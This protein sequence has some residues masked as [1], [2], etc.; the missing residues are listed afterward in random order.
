MRRFRYHTDPTGR[1]RKANAEYMKKARSSPKRKK[2]LYANHLMRKYG[3][4]IERYEEML[5][6]QC[7]KCVICKGE[8]KASEKIWDSPCVDHCHR[9]NKVRGIL[10]RKCNI[11]LHY[12]E[13]FKHRVEAARYL[14]VHEG[15]DKE[16][17]R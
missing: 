7:N 9:T 10:C 6:Q 4:S 1:I 14:R 13:D 16:L 2:Q 8:F 15:E 3:L 12:M 11:A 5:V 17:P